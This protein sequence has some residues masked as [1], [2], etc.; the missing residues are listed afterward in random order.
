MLMADM[1]D[2]IMGK[3][4]KKC[5]KKIL[6]TMAL[7][8]ACMLPCT[9]VYAQGN[10]TG[11]IEI[12]AENP[13]ANHEQETSERQSNSSVDIGRK[14]IPNTQAT[15]E[16]K[17]EN[18]AFSYDGTGTVVDKAT[19]GSKEFYTIATDAGNVFYLIVD[20][21]K[22][23]NN[24]YF[25]DTTKERDLIALAEK[26]EAEEEKDGGIISSKNK[27]ETPELENENKT[28]EKKKTTK[29]P[30]DT[31]GEFPWEMLA[32]ILIAG[33]GVV[34]YFTVIV[35]KKKVDEADE[36]EE[37]FEFDEDDYYKNER[38]IKDE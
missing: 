5:S 31:T 33:V 4:L 1:E 26:A 16:E 18:E 2:R 25:L 8:V 37:T 21:D 14:N 19:E 30:K 15:N 20:K 24:V 27:N 10:P 22:E 38:S 29:K 12:V 13:V 23:S 17:K 6:L 3:R 28:Q 36:F 35:P 32:I 7:I 9:S 11:E 34:V